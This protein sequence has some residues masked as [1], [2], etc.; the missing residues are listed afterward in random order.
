MAMGVFSNLCHGEGYHFQIFS[1]GRNER[2]KF[3]DAQPTQNVGRVHPPPPPPLVAWQGQSFYH[4][5]A[6]ISSI[7]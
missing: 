5:V 2:S 3:P 7:Q 1:H 6:N 4:E